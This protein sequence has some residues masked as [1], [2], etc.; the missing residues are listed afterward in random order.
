MRR[1]PPR[2]PRRGSSMI[3]SSPDSSLTAV[4]QRYRVQDHQCFTVLVPVINVNSS[5]PA[6]RFQQGGEHRSALS[7]AGAWRT[8]P[9]PASEGS[10]CGRPRRTAWVSACARPQQLAE[11]GERTAACALRTGSAVGAGERCA[12]DGERR[13][14]DSELPQ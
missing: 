4:V 13:A 1:P 12:A 3:A 6:I 14:A 9:Q 8:G 11:L 2:T 7:M 10:G 5:L